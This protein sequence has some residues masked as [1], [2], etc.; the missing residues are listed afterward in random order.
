MTEI[1]SIPRPNDQFIRRPLV[2]EQNEAILVYGFVVTFFSQNCNFIL[3]VIYLITCT[4]LMVFY[5]VLCRLPEEKELSCLE[6]E[7][8]N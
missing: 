6:G 4:V 2:K 1:A 8:F 5:E 3:S 7:H